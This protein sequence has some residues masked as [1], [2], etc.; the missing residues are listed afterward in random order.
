MSSRFTS[1]LAGELDEFLAYKRALGH[2][3]ARSEYTLRSFDRFVRAH[4][5]AAPHR[6]LDRLLL[7]WLSRSEGRK[8]VSVTNELATLRQFCLFRRRRAPAA[9]VPGRVWAPQS[10]E[11]HFLPHVLS[12]EQVRKLLAQAHE[13][14]SPIH[15]RTIRLLVL[16][17]YC[18]GVRVGEALRLELGD[19]DLRAGSF[20]VRHSKGRSRIVPFG[21]D[22]R[23][24]LRAYR[25][26]RDAIAD[27]APSAALFVRI[28]GRPLGV[29]GGSKALR[30]LMRQAGLK[31]ARGRVG[32][33]P[34][35]LRHTFAVHRL[36]RWHRAGVDANSRLP[37]LSAY[38]GHDDI[39]G[40]EVYLTATPELLAIAARRFEARFRS[41]PPR[42]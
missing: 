26:R 35:D 4:G 3:Y 19:V 37:L 23:A 6:D 31:P 27:T 22:L 28:D 10:T 12:E 29:P 5:G 42:R 13:L 9:F 2:P 38:M 17:L 41:T 7:A 8:P 21:R 34:Y 15:R 24:E 1:A 33:R 11:S 18:T 32:P 20:L 14:R 25:G 36:T 30:E 40:T 16:V 39:L